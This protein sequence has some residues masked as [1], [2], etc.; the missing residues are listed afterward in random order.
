MVFLIHTEIFHV[1]LKEGYM[2]I[3]RPTDSL[4]LSLSLSLYL[5][6][7]H[8]KTFSPTDAVMKHNSDT[9][10]YCTT[11]YNQ[12]HSIE[13]AGEPSALSYTLQI[14]QKTP[15]TVIATLAEA[16]ILLPIQVNLILASEQ[17]QHYLFLLQIWLNRWC[18]KG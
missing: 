1:Q 14:C 15:N 17:I 8:L 7:L 18:K 2:H 3:F 11:S 4:S 6:H 9:S 5:Y 13:V 12:D 10:N 16:T